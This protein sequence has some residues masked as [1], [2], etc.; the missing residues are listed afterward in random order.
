VGVDDND[1]DLRILSQCIP[2]HA[3]VAGLER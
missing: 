2:Q 1:V 3:Q